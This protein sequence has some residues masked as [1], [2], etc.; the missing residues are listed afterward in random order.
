MI[1]NIRMTDK[2]VMV[3]LFLF[4]IIYLVSKHVV[5]EEQEPLQQPMPQEEV[6][7]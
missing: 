6:Q 4:A 7:V 2:I 1:D 3:E 5:L